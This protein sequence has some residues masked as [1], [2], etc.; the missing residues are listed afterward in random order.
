MKPHR[1]VLTFLYFVGQTWTI[2]SWESSAVVDQI[3]ELAS[4]QSLLSVPT[5]QRPSELSLEIR[6]AHFRANLMV[7]GAVFTT[8]KL[9]TGL[10]PLRFSPLP[11]CPCSGL[12]LH[13]WVPN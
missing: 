11:F 12:A 3:V 9:D 5:W 8:T 6:S 1:M 13:L 7:R 2:D 4:T 10:V